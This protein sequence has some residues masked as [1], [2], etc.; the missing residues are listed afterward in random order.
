[1][2]GARESFL[3]GGSGGD[4]GEG[5]LFMA[6]H[7]ELQRF[8]GRY[9]IDSGATQVLPSSM[10]SSHLRHHGESNQPVV[11]WWSLWGSVPSGCGTREQWAES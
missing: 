8:G 4:E 5:A 7:P 6:V 9:I 2:E 10:T 1:M 11:C 3:G